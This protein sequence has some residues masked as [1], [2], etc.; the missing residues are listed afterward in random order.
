MRGDSRPA[1]LGLTAFSLM[2]VL[3]GILS[4]ACTSSRSA[5]PQFVPPHRVAQPGAAPSGASIGLVLTGGGA[6]GAW[7]V[8]ALRAFFDSWMSR[9]GEEPPI[10]VVVGT[11]T[12]A[13][14]APFAFL[15]R[16][17]AHDFI[18][19]VADWY[20]SVNQAD[21]VSFRLG[22]LLPFPLFAVT[23]SSVYGVGYTRRPDSASGRLYGR[24]VEALPQVKLT[25]LSREWPTRRLAVTTLDFG[26]GQP[27]VF[28]NAPLDAAELREGILASAMAP[29]ALPPIPIANRPVED[30][31]PTVAPHFDGGVYEVA[32]FQA[33]FDLAALDPPIHLSHIVVISAFPR[34]PGGETNP[35]QRGSFPAQPKFR[36]IGDRMNVLLSEAAVTTDIRLADAAIALR[37]R[38]LDPHAVADLTGLAIPGPPPTLIVLAPAERLGWQAFRFDPAEMASMYRRGYEEARARLSHP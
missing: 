21:I 36:A 35:V 9:Y 20:T 17:P 38:G 2:G 12:G 27:H 15:G 29:L 34:F 4:A 31:P 32:P 18:A 10:S 1:R 13:L 16:S 30:K 5:P 25:A 23:T 26:S 33:L 19:D 37:R 8:G 28:T 22:T 6:F 24:L 11:S 14:I 3:S 7:E